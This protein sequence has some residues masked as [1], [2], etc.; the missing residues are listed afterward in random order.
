[1][2]ALKCSC[3]LL[4]VVKGFDIYYRASDGVSLTLALHHTVTHGFMSFP[5]SSPLDDAYFV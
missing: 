2:F 5:A 1:M 3:E 4:W